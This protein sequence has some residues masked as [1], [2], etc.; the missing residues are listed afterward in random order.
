M[1]CYLKQTGLSLTIFVRA[2]KSVI[3]TCIWVM[4]G[5]TKQT[6]HFSL[7]CTIVVTVFRP[8]WPPS[9]ICSLCYQRCG[10]DNVGH[11]SGLFVY[12]FL[13]LLLC[14]NFKYHNH[15]HRGLEGCLVGLNMEVCWVSVVLIGIRT[16]LDVDQ[17]L[18]VN[19]YNFLSCHWIICVS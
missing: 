3:L 7:K 18:L 16:I 12:K 6:R 14:V 1:Y 19:E 15:H 11:Y 5:L 10:W 8:C 9:C 17:F 2:F 4:R 13:S